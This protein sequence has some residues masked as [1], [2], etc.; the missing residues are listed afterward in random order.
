MGAPAPLVCGLGTP[1]FSSVVEAQPKHEFDDNALNREMTD[2]GVFRTGHHVWQRANIMAAANYFREA[3]SR[4]PDDLQLKALYEGLLEV[5]D[6]SRRTQRHQRDSVI[7]AIA[8]EAASRA[9]DRRSG[10]DRRHVDVGPPG[11][12]ERRR[13]QDRRVIRNRRSR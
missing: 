6:P 9:K 4:S 12:I 10:R 2:W 13:V 1:G 5:L 8:P 11:G 3:L 7:G